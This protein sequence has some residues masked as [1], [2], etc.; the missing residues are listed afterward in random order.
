VLKR[1]PQRSRKLS[2]VVSSHRKSLAWMS[3]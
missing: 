3:W 2:D 1:N